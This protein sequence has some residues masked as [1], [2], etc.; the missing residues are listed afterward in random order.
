MLLI[1]IAWLAEIKREAEIYDDIKNPDTKF[2][3]LSCCELL[4]LPPRNDGFTM[5]EVKRAFDVK[6]LKA[7]DVSV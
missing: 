1:T 5:M 2:D 4:D 6:S 7:T 3:V